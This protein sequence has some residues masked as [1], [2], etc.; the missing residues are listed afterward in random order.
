MAIEPTTHPPSGG[1]TSTLPLQVVVVT[2]EKAILDERADMVILP[3]IDG[4]LGVL[5][6]RA[7]LVGRLGKGELRLKRGN[8]VRKWHLEGGFAQVRSD[9]VTVLTSKVTG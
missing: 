7:A 9:V 8:E 2:P 4:E 5:R 6:G 3:M 1:T